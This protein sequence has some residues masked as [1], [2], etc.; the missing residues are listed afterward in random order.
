M[1]HWCNWWSLGMDQYYW[2]IP[3][4]HQFN[5]TLVQL[6]KFGNGSVLLI[7]SQTS[8]VQWYTGATGEVWEWISI[9]DPFPNFTSSMVHWCNWWSLGM[10]QYYWSIP[11]LHQLHQCT[12]EVREWVINFIPN[13]IMYNGYNCLSILAFKLNHISKRGHCKFNPY[14]SVKQPWRKWVNESLES[15]KNSWYNHNG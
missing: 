2:S 8:P 14:V 4:L 12:I 6:V 10:D 13:F 1:V 7:H 5:G 3:K 9:T 11:K 15:T